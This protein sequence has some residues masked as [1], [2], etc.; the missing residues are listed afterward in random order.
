MTTGKTL[1]EVLFRFG[2]RMEKKKEEDNAKN[3]S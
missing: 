3:R 2:K 1:A